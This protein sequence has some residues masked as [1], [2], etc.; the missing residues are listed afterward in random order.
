MKVKRAGYMDDGVVIPGVII[1][2][3]FRKPVFFSADGRCGWDSQVIYKDNEKNVV[4]FYGSG[5]GKTFYVEPVLDTL[6]DST[7]FKKNVIA[8][9][10]S[11]HDG[12]CHWVNTPF[13]VLAMHNVDQTKHLTKFCANCP[14]WVEASDFKGNL[15]GCNNPSI[16]DCKPFAEK[17]QRWVVSGCGEWPMDDF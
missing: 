17:Y 12:K 4:E 6:K 7:G 11:Q 9:L 5:S 13:D 10:S 3:L 15:V 16:M 8:H 14:Y 1:K 2:R